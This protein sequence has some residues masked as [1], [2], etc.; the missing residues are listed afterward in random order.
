MRAHLL[1]ILKGELVILMLNER[2]TYWKVNVNYFLCFFYI[3]ISKL[4]IYLWQF[5][6]WFVFLL[7]YYQRIIKD[8]K[9]IL[10]LN[11]FRNFPLLKMATCLMLMFVCNNDHNDDNDDEMMMKIWLFKYIEKNTRNIAGCPWCDVMF[12]TE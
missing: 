4:I 7:E 11:I 1:R 10:F 3:S 8:Y 6:M 9:T 5:N 2:F 12:I